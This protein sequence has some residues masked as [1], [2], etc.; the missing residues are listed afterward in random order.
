[1]FS[2]FLPKTEKMAALRA[3]FRVVEKPM[4]E[5]AS[6]TEETRTCRP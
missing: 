3:T 2:R 1:M 5:T 4:M 6:W